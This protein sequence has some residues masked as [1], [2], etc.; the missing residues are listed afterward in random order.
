MH[1]EQG[2]F[3]SVY[4][5]DFKMVG[6]T[7]NMEAMWKRLKTVKVGSS[8]GLDLEPPVPVQANVYLGCRQNDEAPIPSQINQKA[9]IFKGFFLNKRMQDEADAQKNAK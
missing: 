9:D 3:L 7:E 8:S 2:L 4:V 6:K 1:H 5:D